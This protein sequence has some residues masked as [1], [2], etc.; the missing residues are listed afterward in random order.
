MAKRNLRLRKGLKMLI[1]GYKGIVDNYFIYG[2][3]FPGWK[4]IRSKPMREKDEVRLA[5]YILAPDDDSSGKRLKVEVVET[6]TREGSIDY[7]EKVLNQSMAAHLMVP[8]AEQG[9]ELGNFGFLN[10][11]GMAEGAVLD[12]L[13]FARANL[14]YR[15]TS[16]GEEPISVLELAE[17]IDGMFDT[18]RSNTGKGGKYEL[19]FYPDEK[20]IKVGEEVRFHIGHKG[21]PDMRVWYMIVANTEKCDLYRRNGE[22]FFVAHAPGFINM[23]LISFNPEL[24]RSKAE[25]TFRVRP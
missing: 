11:A 12:F 21:D 8:S 9:V 6:P 25:F 22:Y 15:F 17:A 16:I 7:T 13:T 5:T 10:P 23:L 19:E 4:M 3:E 24:K 14:T 20:G 2:G 1:R 18:A